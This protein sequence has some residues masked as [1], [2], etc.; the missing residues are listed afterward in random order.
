ML[1]FPFLGL[2]NVSIPGREETESQGRRKVEVSISK[3]HIQK[4]VNQTG[5]VSGERDA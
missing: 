2:P 3:L 1:L 5:S 4:L